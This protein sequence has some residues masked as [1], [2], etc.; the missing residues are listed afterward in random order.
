[1][2][3]I[4][5]AL[6]HYRTL[7]ILSPSYKLEIYAALRFAQFAMPSIKLSTPLARKRRW[8]IDLDLQSFP[9]TQTFS[10]RRKIHK[11]DYQFKRPNVFWDGLSRLRHTPSNIRELDSRASYISRSFRHFFIAGLFLPFC[12]SRTLKSSAFISTS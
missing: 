3:G 4:L 12:G 10:K 5:L 1:M 8:S 11:D 6:I 7:E 2:A 9:S